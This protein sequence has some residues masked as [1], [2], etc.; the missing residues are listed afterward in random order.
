MNAKKEALISILKQSGSLAVALSGGVDSSYLLAMARYVLKNNVIAITADSP[1]QPSREKND[2]AETARQLGVKHIIL[3]S[4]ELKLPAFVSNPENRCYICKKYL[5][6]NF[7]KE[8][9]RHGITTTANG[10]NMDDLSDYRPGFAAIKELGIASPLLD[11][12]LTKSDIRQFSK[13]M[14]L[15]TWDKPAMACLATRIPYGTPITEKAL[16][17][18]DEAENVLSDLGFKT[19]RVRHHGNVARIEINPDDYKKIIAGTVKNT[20]INK[21]RE[22]GYSHMALDLEGY[23]SG[24]MNRGIESNMGHR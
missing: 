20:I 16:N 21:F 1:V 7:I 17:M 9:S 12:K 11:A 24:S 10:M 19:C 15:S 18:I 6:E 4:D 22:I 2:A 5:F 13:E 3:Q 14:G 8:A 23:V